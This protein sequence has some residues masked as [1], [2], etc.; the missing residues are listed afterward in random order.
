MLLV[1]SVLAQ[2]ITFLASPALTRLYVP[3]EMGAY[4]LYTSAI[5]ILTLFST[6]RYDFA[7]ISPRYDSTAQ[8]LVGLVNVIA[9]AFLGISMVLAIGFVLV[10]LSSVADFRYLW[11]LVVPLGVFFT[12]VHLSSSAYLMR[13][14]RTAPIAAVR[15]LM[16]AFSSVLAIVFGYVGFGV[17]GL[18]ASSLIALFV[19]GMLS[20][21]VSGLRILRLTARTRLFAVAKR[22]IDY[23]RVD[24]PSSLFGVV[25]GQLPVLLL[26]GLFGTSFLGFYALVERILFAPINVFGGAIGSVFRVR[27]T[28]CAELQGDFRKE[29]VRTF[30]HILPLAVIIYFPLFFYGEEIFSYI[31]GSSWR[32]AGEIAQ[33]LS[34]LYFF[35]LF[36]SPL[37]M[38]LYVRNRMRIDLFGQFSLL[39]GAT[40]SMVAGGVFGDQLLSLKL[41]TIIYS[42]VYALYVIYSYHISGELSNGAT[43]GGITK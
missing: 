24:L 10:S 31:F 4:A 26:G 38:S 39:F 42:I 17:W 18:L 41:M 27:A 12:S 5:A 20:W 16:A 9:L 35:R 11:V 8:V 3:S 29:Y 19:G 14:V 23:P 13:H 37:S 2:A 7:V 36:T 15:I 40:I 22:Y 6:A 1:G 34:P 33:I 43:A 25:G 28:K 32:G 21:H 30:L